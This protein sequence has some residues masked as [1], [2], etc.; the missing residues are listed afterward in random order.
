MKENKNLD[1]VKALSAANTTGSPLPEVD[2]A[3][4]LKHRLLQIRHEKEKTEGK[5]TEAKEANFDE[6]LIM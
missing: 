2:L 1:F 4:A 3:K 5:Q 6:G